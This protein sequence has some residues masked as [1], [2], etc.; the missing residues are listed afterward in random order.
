MQPNIRKIPTILLAIIG[1]YLA[2]SYLFPLIFPFLT[3]AFLA[4]GAEP[5][6]SFGCEKLRLPRSV[7]AVLGVAM[8]F[9]IVTLAVLLLGALLLRELGVLAGIL[10]NLETAALSGMENLSGWL[11]NLAGR[12]P[13]GLGNILSRQVAAFFSDSAALIENLISRLLG[14]ASGMLGRVTGSALA[15]ITAIISSFMFSARL[16][17]LKEIFRSRFPPEK[18]QAL[19]STLARLKSALVG[20]LKAQLKLCSITGLLCAAGF[21]LLGIRNGLLWALL[22]AVVD[23]FPILGVGT[24]LIPWSLISFLRGDRFLAFGLLGLYALCAV[25]R[26]VLEPRLVGKHLGL[27]PL[28]TLI[29]LYGGYRLWGFPGMLL[30]PAIAVSLSQ[31]TRSQP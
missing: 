13:G 15:F 10:P 30:A 20:W 17:K 11:L 31:L 4:F 22:V 14:L 25:T 21:L 3:G 24:A 23:A 8:T 29:A 1:I 19:R 5:L 28:I 27:D 7:S 2:V 6:V 9:A 16:P 26:S 12:I 18:L